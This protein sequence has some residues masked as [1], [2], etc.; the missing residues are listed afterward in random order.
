MLSLLYLPLVVAAGTGCLVL[1]QAWR[2]LQLHALRRHRAA[3]V[4]LKFD[5]NEFGYQ[6]RSGAWRGG[7]VMAGGLVMPWLTVVRV[8]D[9]H[10]ATQPRLRVLVLCS[11]S[12]NGD[13][14]RKLRVYLRWRWHDADAKPGVRG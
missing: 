4:A 12:L 3:I 7:S 14:Y 9:E 13:D 5:G 8:R 1:L 6:L 11:D 2:A 10:S